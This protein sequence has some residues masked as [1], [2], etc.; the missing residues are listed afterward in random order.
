[1]SHRSKKLAQENGT[2]ISYH[3]K[4]SNKL[5]KIINEYELRRKH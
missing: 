4:G 3:F 5:K 2:L 1:M